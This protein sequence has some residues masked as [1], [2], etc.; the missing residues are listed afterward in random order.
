MKL[1]TATILETTRVTEDL[2]AVRLQAPRIAQEA[3]P[4]QF[5]HVRI[6]DA[7]DPL[8]RRPMSIYRIGSDTIDFLV[9]MAGR[10]S[11]MMVEKPAGEELDCLGPLGNGFTVHPTTRN[12]L[13][14]G[15]GSGVAPLV[16]LA[17]QAV[18]KGLSV[19]LLFGARS[20]D[21]VFPA[22]LLPPELEYAVATDDGSLGR[23]GVVTDLLPDYLGWADAVYACGPRAMFLS[24][25]EVVR[26]ANVQKS[27]QLSLEENM[28]CGVG[29]CFG[30]VVE[31]R[32]GEMKSVCDDGPVFEMRELAWG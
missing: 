24:M 12:L 13:M 15:G 3:R 11:R 14:V 17:E 32:H 8:L 26:R 2:W 20:A 7:I 28:A 6:G 19:V 23:R 30:C 10:G 18:A 4:G 1:E 22:R 5:V 21:R 31:T 29:A 27:V 9:R 25:L 16:A